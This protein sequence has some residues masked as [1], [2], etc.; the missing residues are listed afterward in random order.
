MNEQLPPAEEE[1]RGE[2]TQEFEQPVESGTSPRDPGRPKQRAILYDADGRAYYVYH[3]RQTSGKRS[4]RR[5][6]N[7]PAVW[8]ERYDLLLADNSLVNPKCVKRSG[9]V[10]VAEEDAIL[11]FSRLHW[12]SHGPLQIAIASIALLCVMSW[13]WL[14]PQLASR[15]TGNAVTTA[16]WF[17]PLITLAILAVGGL[18]YLHVWIPWAYRYLVVTN[19]RIMLMYAPP[20]GLPGDQSSLFLKDV[21]AVRTVDQAVAKYIPSWGNLLPKIGITGYKILEGDSAADNDAWLRDGI[22]YV[23]N[24]EE[25]TDAIEDVK[26]QAARLETERHAEDMDFQQR[27]AVASEAM[28]DALGETNTLL[29]R[30]LNA[31]R[32]GLN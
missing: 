27:Q 18:S 4:W 19:V 16:V 13:F 12:W 8:W 28:R 6:L 22:R 15:E 21:L 31:D 9:F 30:L 26:A 1:P 3:K 25:V 20:F 14:L 11:V 24:A 29:N 32:G 7:K 17:A 5:P 23:R 10:P 2:Q